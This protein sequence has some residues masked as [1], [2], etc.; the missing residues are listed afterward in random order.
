[1]AARDVVIRDLEIS[2]KK[3]IELL[4]STIPPVAQISESIAKN[5]RNANLTTLPAG[6]NNK[7]FKR[8]PILSKESFSRP[9]I[10]MPLSHLTSF[11]VAPKPSPISNMIPPSQPSQSNNRIVEQASR[12]HKKLSQI[13]QD[14][15]NDITT[16]FRCG[17]RN[18]SA[19]DC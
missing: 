15:A 17:E 13:R 2:L 14:R 19:R 1:M 5:S 8:L 4:S 10:I 3:A 18:H 6:P 16:C 12:A 7:E 9:Q 11:T